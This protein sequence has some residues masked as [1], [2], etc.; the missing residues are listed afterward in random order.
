LIRGYPR[1]RIAVPSPPEPHPST[2]RIDFDSLL[3]DLK[4]AHD[5]LDTLDGRLV[6]QHGE[7]E[8]WESTLNSFW[9]FRLTGRSQIGVLHTLTS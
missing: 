9:L 7:N 3:F 4:R 5:V 6:D 1:E 2:L 8:E